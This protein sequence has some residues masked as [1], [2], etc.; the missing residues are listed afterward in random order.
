MPV[1]LAFVTS[2]IAHHM[3]HGPHLNGLPSAGL[4]IDGKTLCAT[5]AESD[6]F[7]SFTIGF[8]VALLSVAAPYHY[9]A[10]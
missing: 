6:F 4:F 9:G 5:V 3:N 1:W 7:K 2:P 10:I 8:G